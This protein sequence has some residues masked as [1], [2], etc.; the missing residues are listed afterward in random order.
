MIWLGITNS[1]VINESPVL[2]IDIGGGSTELIVG[3]QHGYSLLHSLRLGSLRSTTQFFL[4]PEKPIPDNELKNFRKYLA[5]EVGSIAH[6]VK[7]HSP[8]VGIGSSGTIIALESLAGKMGTTHQ[9]GV[10]T[11]K[12]LKALGQLLAGLSHEERCALPGMQ[13]DRADIIVAGSHILYEVMKACSI[14]EIRT[15]DFGLRYGMLMDYL[16]RSPGFLPEGN[17]SVRDMSIH[18]L[19]QMFSVDQQ[20][21]DHVSCLVAQMFDSARVAG[22]FS[23][24]NRWRELLLYAARVHDVGQLVSLSR[25]QLHSAYIVSNADIVGF[26]EY[27]ILIISLF[28]RYHRKRF[29]REKDPGYESLSVKDKQA[30]FVLSFILRWAEI[31]DRSHDGRVQTAVLSR[32]GDHK[33]LLELTAVRACTLEMWA[34][35]EEVPLFKNVFDYDVTIVCTK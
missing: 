18:R 9:Q 4:N 26:S 11:R 25:H 12:E 28:C 14:R 22:F 7:K 8:I 24:D 13:K 34:V 27:E 21:A 30:V 15:T 32:A 35:E 16:S 23:Y 2:F 3:D 19:S 33:V 29:P 20:H 5:G 17:L 31:L 1:T 6:E 10:L